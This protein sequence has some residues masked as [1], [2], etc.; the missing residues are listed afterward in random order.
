MSGPFCTECGRPVEPG[1]KFCGE[2]GSATGQSVSAVT[3][4][5]AMPGSSGLTDTP[6]AKTHPQSVVSPPAVKGRRFRLLTVA[7]VLLL[8][9]AALAGVF[10]LYITDFTEEDNV[11]S[12]TSQAASQVPVVKIG[13]QV[14]M[15]KNI[16]V[17]TFRN[18]NSISE[19]RTDDEWEA[20]GNSG[21]PAWSYYDNDPAKGDTYGKLYNWHAVSDPRGLCPQGWHVPINSDWNSMVSFLGGGAVAG[22][23]IKES[24]R[25]YWDPPVTGA[26]NSSGFSALPGGQRSRLGDYNYLGV[27]AGFWS[28]T[29]S[30]SDVAWY[31]GMSSGST[32]IYRGDDGKEYGWSVRCVM[33]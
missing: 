11:I 27:S 16:D 13:N 23:K 5:V 33:D 21:R 7:A 1:A 8:I 6:T 31:W 26:T 22:D 18:G 3:S 19:A 30:G 9:A 2:C 17:S 15:A 28:A 24:G 29:E 12:I 4:S 25:L 10:L 20:A 32:D 14:W